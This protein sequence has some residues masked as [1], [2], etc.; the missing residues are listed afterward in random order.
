MEPARGSAP[1]SQRAPAVGSSVCAFA[2]AIEFRAWVFLA[3]P[4]PARSGSIKERSVVSGDGNND[5]AACV[6]A[7]ARERVPSVVISTLY[8]G[9]YRRRTV[10]LTAGEKLESLEGAGQR[11]SP[12]SVDPEPP[13]A[14]PDRVGARQVQARQPCEVISTSKKHRKGRTVSAGGGNS[15]GTRRGPTS[16]PVGRDPGAD[17]PSRELRKTTCIRTTS[18]PF[19]TRPSRSSTRLAVPAFLIR[20][21]QGAFANARACK[22]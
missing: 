3:A 15:V 2:R 11:P 22:C 8:K 1:G 14:D 4:G 9:G 18:R 6:R 17:G 5:S 12:R 16:A 13:G 19:G 7:I 20:T 21:V 10:S